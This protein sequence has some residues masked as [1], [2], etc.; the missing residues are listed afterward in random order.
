MRR[1]ILFAMAFLGFLAGRADGW[2][3][4]GPPRS[5]LDEFLHPNTKIVAVCRLQNAVEP[6]NN[7][8]NGQIEL[9]LDDLIVPHA[10]VLG[11]KSILLPY[12][13]QA[14]PKKFLV[15]LELLKNGTIDPIVGLEMDAVGETE[16]FVR[17]ALALKDKSGAGRAAYAVDF[18]LSPN[19]GVSNSAAVELGR[20]GRADFRKVAKTSRP[21]RWVEALK[22]DKTE[23]AQLAVCA[24]LLAHCGEKQHAV[25][26]RRLLD[27]PKRSG[28]STRSEL[29]LAYVLLDPEKGWPL[30]AETPHQKGAT[31]MDSYAA[32]KAVRA[33]YS[34]YKDVIPEKKSL[35]AIA[36]LLEV[37]ALADFA[38]EDMRRWQRWEYCDAI[39]Q[40]PAKKG[41]DRPIIRRS[42]LR[43]ALQCPTQQAKDYVNALRMR[44]QELVEETE[45]LLAL[46]L[47][48][49][50][51]RKK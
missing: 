19:N 37:T 8:P 41:F 39:L 10:R 50:K 33:V 34:E 40:M 30:V 11:R 14:S 24:M 1:F 48:P 44:D 31:F 13:R 32:L 12:H 16:R 22:N 5:L 18:L 6:N 9:M 25:V 27:D 38:V 3:G 15:A 28:G 45:E 21:D 20:L 36:S 49:A 23:P 46:E 47:A 51:P 29:F 42:V 7:L 43:F 4:L 2:C 26:V 17:G 35:A